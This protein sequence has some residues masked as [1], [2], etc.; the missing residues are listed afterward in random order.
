MVPL[1]L[2]VGRTDET[3]GLKNQLVHLCGKLYF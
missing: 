3:V 2:F 1:F